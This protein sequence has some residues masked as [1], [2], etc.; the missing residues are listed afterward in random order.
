MTYANCYVC[1]QE[2]DTEDDPFYAIGKKAGSMIIYIE[3]TYF[4]SEDCFNRRNNIKTS[5][6]GI[7]ITSETTGQKYRVFRWEDLGDGKIAS[8]HKVKVE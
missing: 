1:Q 4:C 8:I 3:V 5:I 6:E 7:I 2:I